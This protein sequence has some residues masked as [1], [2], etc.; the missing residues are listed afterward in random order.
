MARFTYEPEYDSHGELIGTTIKET[1]GYFAGY[2]PEQLAKVA[3]SHF[4]NYQSF[5]LTETFWAVYFN[6]TLRK[7][8]HNE[9][10]VDTLGLVPD[11]LQ[12]SDSL[13]NGEQQGLND[14]TTGG[15]SEG[16]DTPTTGD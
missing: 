4:P 13:R 6:H 11:P 9:E 5:N 14:T 7:A 2:T 3:E 1:S 15:Q 8:L 16:G 10:S 12:R